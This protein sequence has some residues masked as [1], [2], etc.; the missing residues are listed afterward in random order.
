MAKEP[1]PATFEQLYAKLEETVAKIEAGGMPLEATISLYEEGM[2]LA[3]R[4][5]D[6][7]DEAEQ[8]VT[9]LRESF[10]TV[11]DRPNGAALHDASLEDYEYVGE[12]AE[13][14]PGDEPFE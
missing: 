8:K 1:K 11:P 12:A 4:C 10:A 14:A 2:D 3:R 9:R 13:D 6:R 5:Q 7:L